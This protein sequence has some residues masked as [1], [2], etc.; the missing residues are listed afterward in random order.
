MKEPGIERAAVVAL[1]PQTG[2]ILALYSAPSFD[3]NGFATGLPAS[4]FAALQNN[5]NRPLFNRAVRGTYPPGSTIKPILSLAALETGATNLTRRSICIG[6][7][8]LPGSTHRYRDWRPEGHGEVDLHDAIEQSCD[9]YFYEISRDI[10]ID[11]M[12]LG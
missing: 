7:Y 9:V 6:F 3:P 11:N 5:E 8:S 12:Q 10:G 4:E 2:D 1:D